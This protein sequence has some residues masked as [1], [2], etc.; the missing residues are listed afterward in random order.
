MLG[1]IRKSKNL[2]FLGLYSPSNIDYLLSLLACTHFCSPYVHRQA[3]LVSVY[4]HIETFKKLILAIFP[5]GPRTCN[6]RRYVSSSAAVT[7]N[8]RITGVLQLQSAASGSEQPR[9]MAFYSTIQARL[10]ILLQN[11]ARHWIALRQPMA[12][13]STVKLDQAR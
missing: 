12:Q 1:P 6:E 8:R 13:P 5:C 10:S 11:K 7:R 9:K 2:D 3:S 4:M